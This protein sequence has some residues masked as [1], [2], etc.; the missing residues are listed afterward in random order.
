VAWGLEAAALAWLFRRIPHR[1]LLLWSGGL[2]AAVF[3]RLTLNPAIFGYYRRSA[4]PVWNWYLY[5]YLVVAGAFFVA[6]G[7][8]R[9]RDDRLKGVRLSTLF[10]SGGTILLFVL[11]NIEIA[12][13]FGRG[14]ELTFE[15]LSDNLARG[16]AYTLG[17]AAFAFG[18]LIAG[19][20]LHNRA[21]RVTALALLVVTILKC[22]L[23]DLL[24]LGGLYV[25]G[26]LVGLGVCLFAVAILLQRFVIRAGAQPAEPS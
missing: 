18:L 4:H 11:L 24:R 14:G 20:L 16:L 5:T 1:G 13:C 15:L 25:V 3:V 7:L 6:N 26:S 23:Y 8:L 2:G 19:I 21:A 22:F 9:D 10:A 17:W 12:D